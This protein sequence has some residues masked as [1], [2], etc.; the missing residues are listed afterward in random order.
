MGNSCISEKFDNL[1]P[2]PLLSFLDTP[3][4]KN[5]YLTH[6]YHRYPAKFIPQLASHLI[7]ENTKKGDLICDPFGGCGTSLVEAKV[8]GRKSVGIDINPLA[9]LITKAKVTPIPINKLDMEYDRL[10]QRI[11]RFSSHKFVIPNDRLI[12]W[13]SK[14]TLSK[15]S[16]IDQA[17]RVINDPQIR[18]FIYCA[19]SH[20]LKNTSKWLTKSIK[21]TIDKK[22]IT[23]D[24]IEVFTNHSNFMIQQNKEFTNELLRTNNIYT[25][26]K[27]YLRDARK[28]SL[29]TDSI[30]YILTS[31]PYVTSYEYADLHQLSLFWLGY[32]KNWINFKKKFI[33]SSHNFASNKN[34]YSNIAENIIDQM[35][36]RDNL[37][38]KRIR[39]YFEDMADFFIEA[40]RILRKSGKLSLVIGN[41]VIRDINI[42]NAEV[43][44]EQMNCFGF[45]Q[46]R[47]R[48][49]QTSFQ[50]ITPFRDKS[51]GRFTSVVNP[52][53]RRVYQYEYIITSVS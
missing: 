30:D 21:P 18:R 7:K 29:P 37:V 20:I 35:D 31:P 19:F 48:K 45:K 27:F 6:G 36:Q 40:K 5:S 15:L 13:F 22:K 10:L 1:K 11:R 52:N 24:P 32:D 25:K 34:L 4:S 50:S 49:R 53:S 12:K 17:I 23:A 3:R 14:D 38:A 43:A 51:T 46:I 44:Y 2:D 8:N 9:G 47:V 28:T 42:L 39:A 41:T 16:S 33:G 26:A